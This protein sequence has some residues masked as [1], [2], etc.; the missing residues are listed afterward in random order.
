MANLES[1]MSEMNT[2][3]RVLT[4]RWEA[5][6]AVWNDSVERDFEQNYWTPTQAHVQ[7]TQRE[8]ERLAQVIAH[9]G[10]AYSVRAAQSRAHPR[11]S[12]AALRS[13]HEFCQCEIH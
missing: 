2:A 8:M 7:A 4:Q 11:L 9:V 5:T 1:A 12:R 3:L 6:Q 13:S 10:R